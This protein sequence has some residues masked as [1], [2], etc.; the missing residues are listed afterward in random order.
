MTK[1]APHAPASA[2][3]IERLLG[4]AYRA[5]FALLVGIGAALCFF[6]YGQGAIIGA[7]DSHVQTQIKAALDSPERLTLRSTM[8]EKHLEYDRAL[9]DHAGR[10][11]A[12]ERS[13]ETTTL[14][15]VKI[16][17]SIEQVQKDVAEIRDE[18]RL[19]QR[20]ARELAT[21]PQPRRR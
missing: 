18:Q 19:E 12:L 9:A 1:R 11:V 2:S 5:P 17:G 13:T 8:V 20:A 6:V 14:A 10:I 3:A 7:L 16:S 21:Q 15:L 4:T